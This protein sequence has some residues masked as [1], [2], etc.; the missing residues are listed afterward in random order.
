MISHTNW[1]AQ[2]S[3]FDLFN[4]ISNKQ[5]LPIKGTVRKIVPS[6]PFKLSHSQ[7]CAGNAAF[8]QFLQE[9]GFQTAQ[10][11]LPAWPR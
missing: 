2:I 6:T 9:R 7:E 4:S 5:S 8:G 11:L 1:L 10:V 3:G